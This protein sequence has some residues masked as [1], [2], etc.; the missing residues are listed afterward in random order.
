MCLGGNQRGPVVWFVALIVATRVLVVGPLR[1]VGLVAPVAVAGRHWRQITLRR[2]RLAVWLLLVRRLLRPI[3]LAIRGAAAVLPRLLPAVAVSAGRTVAAA[4][5][6]GSGHPWAAAWA[7]A[8]RV[9][10]LQPVGEPLG[11]LLRVL[12][13]AAQLAAAPQVVLQRLTLLRF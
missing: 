5:P 1:F 4:V 2:R 6:A 12:K 13:A 3:P 7:A 9:A 8:V 10:L 11:F